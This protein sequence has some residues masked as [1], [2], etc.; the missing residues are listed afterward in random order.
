MVTEFQVLWSGNSCNVS[1]SL[2]EVIILGYQTLM[3]LGFIWTNLGLDAAVEEPYPGMEVAVDDPNRLPGVG[4]TKEVSPELMP[5]FV[6]DWK[7]DIIHW[8]TRYTCDI[9]FIPM[10]GGKNDDYPC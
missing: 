10:G 3:D 4:A 2:Q 9:Y 1:P 8:Q 6:Q 5:P 7:R